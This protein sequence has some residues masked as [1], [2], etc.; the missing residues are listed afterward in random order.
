MKALAGLTPEQLTWCQSMLGSQ[1]SYVLSNP[2]ELNMA[3]A[4]LVTALESTAPK[5]QHFIWKGKLLLL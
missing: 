1:R 3:K 5:D 4:E 2:F